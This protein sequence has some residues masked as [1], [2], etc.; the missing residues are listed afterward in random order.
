M[1]FRQLCIIDGIFLT[2]QK[3]INKQNSNLDDED[4]EED[5]T[6]FSSEIGAAD[7]ELS[8]FGDVSELSDEKQINAML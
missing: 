5:D 2:I 6:F 4:F 8:G 1:C 7:E 3:V